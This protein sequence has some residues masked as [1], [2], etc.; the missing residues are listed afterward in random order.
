[1]KFVCDRCQT[2]YSIADERVRGKVLKVK[3]KTCANLITVREARGPSVAGLPTLS[4]GGAGSSSGAAGLSS[5]GSRPRSGAQA[6]LSIPQETPGVD[7]ERTQ[8]AQSPFGPDPDPFPDL[9]AAPSPAAARRP[10]GQMA[11]VAPADDGVQWYMALDGN[12]TG[13]F[14]RQKL[15]DKLMPL[16]KNADVHIWNERLD[17]WKPPSGVA[18]VAAEIG[19][20]RAP[21]PPPPL[22]GAPRRPTPPPMAPLAGP[23]HGQPAR[24]PTGP[25][26]P[27]SPTAHGSGPI[28]SKLPPPG[29]IHPALAARGGH[30]GAAG[31]ASS[32]LETPAPMAMSHGLPHKT[33]GVGASGTHAPPQPVNSDVLQ[34]L[35]LPGNAQAAPGGAPKLMSLTSMMSMGAGTADAP[36]PRSKSAVLLLGLL[37]VIALI[38]GVAVFSLKKP[39]RQ[40]AVVVTPP[41]PP[42]PPE[43]P[44]AEKPP[45]EPPAPPVEPPQPQTPPRGKVVKGRGKA[46]KAVAANTKQPDSP[47]TPPAP[48]GSDA[49]RFRDNHNMKISPGGAVA[50]RPPPAQGDIMKVIGNNRAGIKVCY[51]RALTR[52]NSL[53]HGKLSVKLS[54]GISGRVKHVG[55]DGP[56]QFRVLLEPCIKEVV[57]RW[58]FPQASEEY[59]T[60]FP[61][62]FQGNE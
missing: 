53:T 32:L 57:Q 58:V 45:V 20:R 18:E 40:P 44:V 5:G 47:V 21:P 4:S 7:S 61:L 8:L 3:C 16:A 17:G 6:A 38:V 56:T 43:P 42:A 22:P 34:M 55:L 51:Q 9:L 30:E 26:A 36:A 39:P 23:P 15:V 31:D 25:H 49:D 59:G 35:N 14:T 19:R 60:E 2:K 33:N 27:P 10:T 62:V 50:S 46:Q 52:D 24:K 48:G 13:P 29:G 11:A 1:M 41:P 12:R 54:I 28:P 37:G